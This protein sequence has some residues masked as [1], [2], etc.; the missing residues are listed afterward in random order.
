MNDSKIYQWGILG[1]ARVNQRL[2]PAIQQNKNSNI[3]SIASRRDGAAQS[4]IDE[5][6][7][8][9]KSIE[10]FHDFDKIIMDD[11]IDIIYIP[12]ANEEHFQPAVKAIQA[13][14]HVLIEK[15]MALKSEEV[16]EIITEA[17][18]NN[19][20]VMEGFMYAFHPQFERIKKIIQNGKIGVVKYAHA[21]F[22]FPIQP[23]R[24][25]RINRSIN[26]GGGALWD[27]GPYAV[28]TLRQMLNAEPTNALANAEL[29][30]HGADMSTSGL[31]NFKNNLRATFD[32]SFECTRR[33][34]FEVFGDKGRI[35]CHTVWQHENDEA[36]IS[37]LIEGQSEKVEHVAKAN[38]FDLEI[39]HFIDCV[40]NNECSSLLSPED[41]IGNA[42]TL[43]ALSLSIQKKSW[44]SI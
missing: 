6:L 25:Y 23:A 5:Y 32:I 40:K 9:H 11:E 41:A 19:V 14:K 33:S 8:N 12:L 2:L 24:F 15:P 44:V 16:T 36:V 34:E 37:Y 18:K 17:K 31:L 30:T 42:K 28:H 43:E 1:A 7:P 39:N 29:N 3:K 21:M 10:C 13:K 4:C 27:I 26:N 38:H 20:I 35:K 22:S